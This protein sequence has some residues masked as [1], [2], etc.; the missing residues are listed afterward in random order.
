VL[1]VECALLATLGVLAW[2]VSGSATDAWLARVGELGAASAP[3][4]DEVRAASLTARLT[5]G[6]GVLVLMLG[7]VL[8]L[9]RAREPM[10][11]P[12]ILPMLVG[13][14]ALGLVLH[15]ATVELLPSGAVALP[16]AA[17]FAQGFLFGCIGAAAMLAAP[18][19]LVELVRRLRIVLALTIVAIFVALAL[20]GTGPG[21]SGAR[22][23]LGSVQPIE[24]VKPLFVAFL[25][26]YLGARAPKL[27]WQRQRVLGLRWP[28]PVLLVP[29]LLA[30]VALFAGLYVVGDLGPVFILAVVFLGMFYAVTRATGWVVVSMALVSVL[31]GTVAVWPQVVNVG[32]VVTR[33]RMWRDP[34]NNE[35]A[36]GDQLGESLWA[37]ASGGTYGQGL[38][39]AHAPIVPAGKTDLALATLAEQLGAAGVLAYLV[40]LATIVLGG[41]WIA[42]R[43]RTAERALLAAGAA[44]LLVSQWAIIHA[45]TYGWL[46]LTGIVV[47]FVSLGRSSMVAF[48]ALVGLLVRIGSEG[49]ARAES[50][51]V[52]ELSGS[53][54]AIGVVAA[55]LLLAAAVGSVDVGVLKSEEITSSILATRLADGTIVNRY[56]PRLMALASQI[57]RGTIEDRHGEPLAITREVSGPRSYPLGDAMGTLLGVHPSRVL[58]P[59]WALE[60]VHDSR[61]RGYDERTE[62]GR[63]RLDLSSF[64]PLLRLDPAERRERVRA[65][66]AAIAE[67]SVR[68]TIDAR[69][70]RSV[71]AILR[72]KV[73]SGARAAAAVVVDVDTGQ[74]LARAQ[75][76][77]LDPNDASWQ[78]GLLAQEAP[79][80]AQFRGTYGAWPD[81]TG[82]QGTFQS[83]SV[84][85]LFTALIAAREG[86]TG[87]EYACTQRDAQGPFFTRPGWTQPI[88]DHARDGNHG[89]VAMIEALAV[90]CNVYFGQLALALGPEP[91]VA[92]REAGVDVGFGGSFDPGGSGTRQLASTGFGQGALAM[93]VSQAAR[94]VAAIGAGGRYRRCPPSLSLTEPCEEVALIED[95]AAM[96]PIL[97]GMRRVLTSGTG[98]ALHGPSGVRVYGKTGTADVQGFAGE[99]PFGIARGRYAAPHSWFVALAEPSTVAE[100]LPIVPGRLAIAVVVPRGGSGASSAGPVAMEIVA[101][102]RTLGY[103]GGP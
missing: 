32:R 89:R 4:L 43:A 65:M 1:L 52:R 56:D 70:Q 11:T 53:T 17:S 31:V 59:P 95:P 38:A 14:C 6:G 60:R 99:E 2:W 30:L 55:L 94:L 83:G 19:D 71:A 40:A 81:K 21:A 90:S 97:S 96:V 102:A 46:P 58:L 20:V 100:S 54:R 51:E 75:A 73:A 85:K 69:L 76:P 92:L 84:G 39:Q 36:Y 86:R 28:R 48:V 23:N 7:R 8:G 67:R 33:I 82:V 44:L 18:F 88:H 57:R 13:A 45:G 37:I 24:A 77:D 15:S 72:R 68:L 25:A 61:L 87:L 16:T 22:I 74:V 91:F 63:S 66:D 12:L 26:T 93:S 49:A 80:S 78:E 98:R 5:F 103:L 42:S 47:P 29:A 101:A 62:N 34:W 35:I 9:L 64:A 41:F 50:E 27:R 10:H 79:F 3:S